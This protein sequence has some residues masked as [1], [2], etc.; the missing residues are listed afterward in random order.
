MPW[1]E[2]PSFMAELRGQ[3]GARARALEFLI[4]TASRSGEVRGARWEEFDSGI[5][6]VPA[7]RMKSGREHRVPLSP[8]CLEILESRRRIGV[9]A[10]V[11]GGERALGVNAL[12]QSLK[13]RCTTHGFRSAF[14][15][16]CGE[17]T[18]YPREIAEAALAHQ[19][20]SAVEQAYRRGD[21][22][23]KRRKL[24]EAWAAFC[25]RPAVAGATVTPIRA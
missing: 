3:E 9:G 24:M 22:L 2:V 6:T 14:R 1:A 10:F 16:W 23:Q 12:T 15:D 13:G 8:R 18:N 7:S 11:F 5:W 4:L 19:V 21:A 17:A 20:G 25:A